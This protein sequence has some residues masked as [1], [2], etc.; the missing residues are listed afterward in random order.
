VEAWRP[1]WT[2]AVQHRLTRIDRKMGAASEVGSL[3]FEV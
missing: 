2:A 1:G 3:K